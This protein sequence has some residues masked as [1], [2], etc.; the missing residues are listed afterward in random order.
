MW[1]PWNQC[2]LRPQPACYSMD[3]M[4]SMW[5]DHGMVNSIWNPSLF[6]MDSIEWSI[7]MTTILVVIVSLHIQVREKN[8]NIS[9]FNPQPQQ[10]TQC[11]T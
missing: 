10:G 2:W 11:S 7:W 9:E 5:N 1:N 4:D 6:H 8:Y 3:I